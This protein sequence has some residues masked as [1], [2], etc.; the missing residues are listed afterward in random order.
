MK[1]YWGSSNILQ[2]NTGDFQVR[3][4]AGD[5]IIS[6]RFQRTR[7]YSMDFVSKVWDV[8][9]NTSLYQEESH[10]NTSTLFLNILWI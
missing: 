3:R 2:R 1:T 8:G 4:S 10:I 9:A 5:Q 7:L 6:T